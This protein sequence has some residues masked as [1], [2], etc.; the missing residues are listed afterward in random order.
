MIFL[1]FLLDVCFYN[2]TLLKTDFLLHILLDKKEKKFFF[3]LILIW[4]DLVLKAHLKFFF[5][6]TILSFLNKKIKLSYDRMSSIISRFFLSYFL[7]KIG[8][9]LL[10]G[11]FFF[12]IYGFLVTFLYLLICHKK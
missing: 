8:V 4:I 9:F 6:Y 7:Y 10:F 5:L 1:L 11:T 12:D 2:F 3:F